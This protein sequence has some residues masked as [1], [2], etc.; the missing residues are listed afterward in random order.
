[1][2]TFGQ[3]GPLTR[4]QAAEA[5]RWARDRPSALAAHAVVRLLRLPPD[6]VAHLEA[7]RPVVDGMSRTGVRSSLSDVLRVVIAMGI[8][9]MRAMLVKGDEDTA[10]PA[11]PG[12]QRA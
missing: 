12:R 6:T 8:E 4:E 9:G 1:M 10:T 3:R 7:L 2:I 5:A 11:T